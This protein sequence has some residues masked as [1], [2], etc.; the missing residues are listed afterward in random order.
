M[1]KLKEMKWERKRIIFLIVMFCLMCLLG[2]SMT[3][4]GLKVIVKEPNDDDMVQSV[5]V[6]S[7]VKIVG[8]K[9]EDNGCI[10]LESEESYIEIDNETGEPIQSVAIKL[11]KPAECMMTTIV[12]VNDGSGFADDLFY[13]KREEIGALSEKLKQ[14]GALPDD[15]ENKL[16]ANNALSKVQKEYD[17]LDAQMY[18]NQTM[19]NSDY[20]CVDVPKGKYCA[21]RIHLNQESIQASAI[22]LHS[23]QTKVLEQLYNKT[24]QRIIAG[25]VVG[26]MGWLLVVV[27]ECKFK[28]SEHIEKT[29]KNHKK[30]IGHHIIHVCIG[31]VLAVPIAFCLNKFRFS[32]L[33][34]LFIAVVLTSVVEVLSYLKNKKKSLE[35]T[36][37]KLLLLIGV[38]MIFFAPLWPFGWDVQSHYLWTTQSSAIHGGVALTQADS[39]YIA[40]EVAFESDNYWQQIQE[41][42]KDNQYAVAEVGNHLQLWYLPGGVIIAVARLLKLGFVCRYHLGRLAQ[43]IVYVLCCYFG[44]KRLRSG[45]LILGVIASMP[46]CLLLATTYSYDYWVICFTL[47][48]CAYFVGM[49]QDGDEEVN[50]RDTCIMSVALFL[51]CMP[52]QIYMPLMLIPLTMFKRKLK[53]KRIGY[54]IICVV[55]MV[56]MCASLF[57]RSTTEVTGTG[58]LRGGAVNPQEQ[59]TGIIQN[60]ANYALIM[61]HFLETYFNPSKVNVVADWAYLGAL[62]CS[63]FLVM[64]LLYVSITDRNEYDRRAYPLL[65]RIYVVPM[66]IGEIVLI[67]T[68]MYLSFTP[69][70]NPVVNGCQGRYM[71]PLLYPVCAIL[72]GGGIP[73]K[74][75]MGK[76]YDVIVMGIIGYILYYSVYHWMLQ[77]IL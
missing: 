34:W 39:S 46:T 73:L 8:G 55:M 11:E 13:Q 51:G 63:V 30:D 68:A 6:N 47:L 32:V 70:G 50:Y 61:L 22:E 41:L 9:I 15:D 59:L 69:V 72:F 60:P 71:L 52:K 77:S 2:I 49:C 23:E 18:R 29:W 64:L 24:G 56:L 67:A 36:F 16:K 66:M 35:G 3:W 44:M 7:S 19:K 4:P 40:N 38:T 1:M 25:I 5:A 42:D 27:L 57:L 26:I 65:A 48:G 53:D 43:L 10:T 54:Y 21:I 33:L 17:K 12:S 58:D 37:A 75:K 74:K 14:L 28:I 62:P 76:W 31:T 20:L 45:K